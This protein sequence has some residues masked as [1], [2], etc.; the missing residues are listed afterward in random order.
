MSIIRQFL[1]FFS[2]HWLML[3]KFQENLFIVVRSNGEAKKKKFRF[4]FKQIECGKLC[5][6]DELKKTTKNFMFA[7][8]CE[9]QR[10]IHMQK[11]A[12]SKISFQI[13]S[14]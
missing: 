5:I 10:T 12:V 11:N 4:Y 1:S 9:R 14:K 7:S 6:C 8:V 13:S 3:Q 2:P